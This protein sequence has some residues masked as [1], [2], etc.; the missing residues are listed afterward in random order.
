MMLTKVSAI[1]LPP[2]VAF[3]ATVAKPVVALAGRIT[4]PTGP[5]GSKVANASLH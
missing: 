5:E 2:F 3:K 1:S 4:A